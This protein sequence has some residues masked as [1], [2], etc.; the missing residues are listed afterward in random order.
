MIRT[1]HSSPSRIQYFGASA[2]ASASHCRPASVQSSCALI[3]AVANE[4]EKVAIRDGIDVDG[5]WRNR[6]RVPRTFVVVCGR[7][8]RRSL[9]AR[10]PPGNRTIRRRGQ[11]S[12]SAIRPGAQYARGA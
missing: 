12:G 1:H 6:R 10:V 11:A 9:A 3:S 8:G 7:C 2:F 5:K 4:L